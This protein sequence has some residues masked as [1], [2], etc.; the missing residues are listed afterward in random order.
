MKGQFE[1]ELTLHTLFPNRKNSCCEVVSYAI[2]LEKTKV[3]D[4][5]Q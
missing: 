5:P 2:P 1:I 3:T 4:N